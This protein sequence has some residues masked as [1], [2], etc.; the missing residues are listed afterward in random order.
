MKADVYQFSE[1]GNYSG[2]VG[3]C[4]FF[5]SCITLVKIT[6]LQNKLQRW[7]IISFL[8]RS[9]IRALIK[10]F[11]IASFFPAFITLL[12][13][14]HNR[15]AYD[16]VAGTIVVK[17]NGVRWYT[18]KPGFYC[19]NVMTSGGFLN[20]SLQNSANDDTELFFNSSSAINIGENGTDIIWEYLNWSRELVLFKSYWQPMVRVSSSVWE[21]LVL[22]WGSYSKRETYF[23]W[24]LKTITGDNQRD[25]SVCGK[26]LEVI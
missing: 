22:Q 17:R 11:S 14:Q 7:H 19:S 6:R 23:S 9:T 2:G 20:L 3:F 5:S 8:S 24:T 15:T 1:M 10:N 21:M 13:F 18:R 12:F 4:V 25:Y 26:L 16:I